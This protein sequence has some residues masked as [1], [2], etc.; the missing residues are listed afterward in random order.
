MRKLK[1]ILALVF[2]TILVM[3]LDRPLGSLPALGRL[4]DPIN[5]CWANAEAVNKDFNLKID[6]KDLHKP[7]SVWM[8]ERMVP[9]IYAAD[10]HDLYYVQGYVH[11]YFRLWQMDMQTRAA[12]GRVYGPR[13]TTAGTPSREPGPTASCITSSPLSAANT[14]ETFPLLT[15]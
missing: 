14:R 2:V 1:A 7:V 5:G 9:H 8:D 4:V 10:D 15:K 12:A 11:A 13:L 6:I 3:L